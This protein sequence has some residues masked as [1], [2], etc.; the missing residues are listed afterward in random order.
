MLQ[1][2]IRFHWICWIHW[3]SDPFRRVLLPAALKL[4]RRVI[5]FTSVCQYSDSDTSPWMSRN[6]SR[7][8]H[9]HLEHTH[10]PPTEPSRAD[11]PWEQISFCCR[12]PWEQ[13]PPGLEQILQYTPQQL[14]HSWEQPPQEQT[15][16]PQS[17]HPP[18]QT[19][20]Q[21]RHLLPADT[22]LVSRSSPLKHDCAAFL[23]SPGEGRP[24]GMHYLFSYC[25]LLIS[26]YYLW[27]TFY[28]CPIDINNFI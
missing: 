2:L 14:R 5:I 15:H 28:D 24:T 11:T 1:W 20:P 9:T 13:T 21:S 23:T 16:I 22:P 26:C 12:H 18:E 25:I 3:I 4:K 17:R 8:R 19:P 6:C 10:T 7:S 27:E